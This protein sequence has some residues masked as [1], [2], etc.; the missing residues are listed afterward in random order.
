MVVH[1]ADE[2]TI[3]LYT[4]VG[5]RLIFDGFARTGIHKF[6]RQSQ[7]EIDGPTPT[8]NRRARDQQSNC[9]P[10]RLSDLR[11]VSNVNRAFRCTECAV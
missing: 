9:R 5:R 11:S 3:V 4:F 6:G 10:N 1:G 7:I 2:S 8:A